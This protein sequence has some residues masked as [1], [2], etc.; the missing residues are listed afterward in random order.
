VLTGWGTQMPAARARGDI[1]G[2]AGPRVLAWSGEF[3]GE[4]NVRGDPVVA[5]RADGRPLR[6]ARLPRGATP[7]YGTARTMV[8]QAAARGS[9]SSLR[10]FVPA[11]FDATGRLI[12]T[13]CA[14]TSV[15]AQRDDRHLIALRSTGQT[16]AQLVELVR[17]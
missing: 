6:L 5:A 16:S 15:V 17:P 10:V 8:G 12:G 14:N 2:V 1:L 4:G 11:V 7:Q 3:F 13:V 9:R